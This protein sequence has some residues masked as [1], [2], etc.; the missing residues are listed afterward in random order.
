MFNCIF[1]TMANDN[2]GNET[3]WP[4]GSVGPAGSPVAWVMCLWFLTGWQSTRPQ[5]SSVRWNSLGL[6]L[7]LGLGLRQEL[8]L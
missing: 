4:V 5:V 6:K 7:K 8:Q 1:L 3:I 2:T